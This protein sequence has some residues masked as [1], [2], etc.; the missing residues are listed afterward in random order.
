MKLCVLASGSS[1]NSIYIES[2]KTKVLLDAGLSA[3]VIEARLRQVGLRPS[4]LDAIIIS[5][6]HMD[7]VR[8]AGILARHYGLNLFINPLAYK[9]AQEALGRLPHI[10]EFVPGSFF[11]VGDLYFEPFSVPHDAVDP[12]GFAI[13]CGSK[14]IGAVTDLGCV[15]HLVREKLKGSD[16]IIIESNHDRKLLMEGPYPWELKQRIASKMGHLSNETSCELLDAVVDEK[17]RYAVL[18]HLSEVNNRPDL[19]YQAHKKVID[20][21]GFKLYI[22]HQHG[23]GEMIAF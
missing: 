13:F 11:S 18:A 2:Q 16:I 14:K 20:R 8:G 15:T 12:V 4:E 23:T 1:G 7:H 9:E 6:E 3:R 21:T 10:V 5:H 17:L 19:A 22:A